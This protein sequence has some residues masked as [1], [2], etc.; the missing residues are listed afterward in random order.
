MSAYIST[1][2]ISSSL[3]QSVL[4]LQSE[5]NVS[6]TEV[7]TGNYADIGLSLGAA[8]GSSVSLQAQNS[9][10]QTI[11]DTNS[12]AST[13]LSATQNGLGSLQS[14]AQSLL[15][16]LIAASGSTSGAGGSR[17]LPPAICGR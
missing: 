15:N 11:S 7:S 6:Q 16:S 17:R 12:A 3:R 2:S 9:L 13:Q 14:S 8:T 1:Q 10:L 5:L 4:N